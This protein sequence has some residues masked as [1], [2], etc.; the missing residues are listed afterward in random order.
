MLKLLLPVAPP[1]NNS[2]YNVVGRG[3]VKTEKYRRWIKQADAYYTLQQL[4]KQKPVLEPYRCKMLFPLNTPGDLDGRAKLIIDWMVSRGLTL[5]DKHLRGLQLE[6]ED[7]VVS[8]R[9]Q[10][11]EIEIT[12]HGAAG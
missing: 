11:V 4:G 6:Y 5:D 10:T 9:T 7:K 2:T 3:R 8:P 12:P 1:L